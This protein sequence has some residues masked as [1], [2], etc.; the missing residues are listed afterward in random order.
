MTGGGEWS[1]LRREV[2]LVPLSSLLSRSFTWFFFRL[3]A[4]CLMLMPLVAFMERAMFIRRV[5]VL[6]QFVCDC[7]VFRDEIEAVE[8]PR[9]CQMKP[10][11]IRP[12]WLYEESPWPDEVPQDLARYQP[13]WL[14]HLWL[15]WQ[16]DQGHMSG[17]RDDGSSAKFLQP[18]HL[19]FYSSAA[20]G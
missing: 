5:F 12:S 9:F 7:T 15:I 6:P 19:Y 1:C 10:L 18:S 13:L 17:S 11:P 3:G 4:E 14:C 2:G 16:N 20:D 8:Q